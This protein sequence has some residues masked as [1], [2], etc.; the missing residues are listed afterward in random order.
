MNTSTNDLTQALQQQAAQA[1]MAGGKVGTP[2]SFA[3]AS[4]QQIQGTVQQ[5]GANYTE[6]IFVTIHGNHLFK[7]AQ[8]APLSTYASE[9]S[10]CF[11]PMRASFHF[12]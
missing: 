8:L 4:W 1:A 12:L 10:L 3:G 2:L 11:A 6:V 9:E 5:S 7:I